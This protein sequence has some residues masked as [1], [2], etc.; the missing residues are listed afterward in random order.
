MRQYGANASM[1]ILLT[2]AGGP[3][4]PPALV[5][6]LN[7][8][9]MGANTSQMCLAVKWSCGKKVC[10]FQISNWS[11]LGHETREVSRHS[12]GQ[13]GSRPNI[14]YILNYWNI[15]KKSYWPSLKYFNH[16]V[17]WFSPVKSWILYLWSQ[18]LFTRWWL[19]Y[20][21]Y[22]MKWGKIKS[23]FIWGE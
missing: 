8:K 16:L 18:G 3:K 9:K 4:G 12:Q 7:N 1:M 23:S 17:L 14:W 20:T 10:N 2:R 13:A 5:S 21:I 11:K 22:L 19:V 6:E 15:T